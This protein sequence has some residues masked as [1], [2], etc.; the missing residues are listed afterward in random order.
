MIL[1]D[2]V[3][4]VKLFSQVFCD[5]VTADRF[6]MA[7]VEQGHL[8]V[9]VNVGFVPFVADHAVDF[10]SNREELAFLWCFIFHA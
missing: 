7:R 3:V 5:S 9:M 1:L 10:R 8:P 4:I 2:F 6:E